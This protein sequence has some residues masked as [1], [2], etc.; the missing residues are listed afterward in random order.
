MCMN[1]STIL[2]LFD[3][4]E[5]KKSIFSM[6]SVQEEE[7][8]REGETGRISHISINRGRKINHWR[9]ISCVKSERNISSHRNRTR[10]YVILR[11]EKINSLAR[12]TLFRHYLWCDATAA[13]WPAAYPTQIPLIERAHTARE[14]KRVLWAV[15]F[16]IYPAPAEDQCHSCGSYNHSHS[17]IKT[18]SVNHYALHDMMPRR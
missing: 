16:R 8:G 17:V 12:S 6:I 10:K 14:N 7:R 2:H 4:I 18:Y 11:V 3:G 13:T 5:M 15:K 1:N 9:N